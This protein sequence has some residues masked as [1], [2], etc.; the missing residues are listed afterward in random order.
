MTGEELGIEI[1]FTGENEN[2][3]GFLTAIDEKLFSAKVGEQYL[4]KI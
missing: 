4:G 3:K 1:S 2:E